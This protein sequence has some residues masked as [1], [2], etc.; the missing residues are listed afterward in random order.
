MITVIILPAFKDEA[1]SICAGCR[2]IAD[3]DFCGRSTAE[4]QKL[5]RHQVG[6]AG[7]CSGIVRELHK[8]HKMIVLIYGRNKDVHIAVFIDST[9][10]CNS[11]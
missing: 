2:N 6:N 8:V 5:A 9:G 3:L 10:S 4:H 1:D 7:S 11:I